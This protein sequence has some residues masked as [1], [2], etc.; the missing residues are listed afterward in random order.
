LLAL[1]AD[2]DPN[3]R[4]AVLSAAER[5]GSFGA[6]MVQ[7]G[8]K[9]PDS[10]VQNRAA[11][12]GLRAGFVGLPEWLAL[13][14]DKYMPWLA[15]MA[16][17]ALARSG[18][19]RALK[20]LMDECKKGQFAMYAVEALRFAKSPAVEEFLKTLIDSPDQ[21]VR[22]T[23]AAALSDYNPGIAVYG[24]V[25]QEVQEALIWPNPQDA[26]LALRQNSAAWAAPLLSKAMVDPYWVTRHSA[27]NA[28]PAGFG[29]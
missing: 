26:F 15:P 14:S 11:I 7:T 25:P 9:D 16:M 27:V 17:E 10:R 24:K 8:L 4:A 6:S 2:K 29:N 18:N 3:R 23:A 12:V 22:F 13:T 28:L 1:L 5:L 19:S 21:R 20:H